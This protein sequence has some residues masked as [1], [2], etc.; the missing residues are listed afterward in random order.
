VLNARADGMPYEVL[1]A[2]ILEAACRR[3]GLPI[4]PAMEPVRAGI[5]QAG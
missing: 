3:Y 1:I 5:P 2:R 4:E